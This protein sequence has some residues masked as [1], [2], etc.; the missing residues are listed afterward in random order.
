MN[1][2]ELHKKLI[3]ARRTQAADDRVPYAFEQRITARLRELSAPVVDQWSAWAGGLW[4]AA[5]PCVA[6][7]LC[8]GAWA[9]WS[10]ENHSTTGDLTQD[11]ESTVLAVAD[12]ESGI[13]GVW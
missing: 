8:L 5:V 6:I 10:P 2:A 3:A 1:L 7:S 4:R 9:F 13:E 11:L 12:Q